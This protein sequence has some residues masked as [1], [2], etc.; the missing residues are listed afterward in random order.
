MKNK[1][2]IDINIKDIKY[3]FF[4]MDGTFLTSK[5]YP[6]KKTLET[7][8]KLK[9]LNINCS[10]ATGRPYFFTK[11]EIKMINPNLPVI[12]CNGALVFDSINNKLISY[13]SIEKEI[14]K[15]IYDVLIKNDGIFI[16]YTKD[17]VFKVRNKKFNNESKWFDWISSHNSNYKQDEQVEMIEIE[18]VNAFNILDYDVIKFL[19]IYSEMPFEK[20][21][22]IEKEIQKLSSV[23]IVRSQNEVFDIMPKGLS[24]GQGLQVLHDKKIID[25]NQTIV[26]GDAENDISMFEVAKW[27]VAMGNSQ[28]IVKKK[29]MFITEDNDNE[30]ISNFFNKLF[31]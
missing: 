7:L 26:F 9:S 10:I 21:E 31:D 11:N 30:G 28:S 19:I 25:L 22:L 18:D 4:D 5:K 3:V 8:E 13:N 16:I 24:K 15:I 20:Y 29:A 12:S 27:N 1:T 23:Y 17:K 2:N 14:S 6:S